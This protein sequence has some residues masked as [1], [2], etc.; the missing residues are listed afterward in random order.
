MIY[1][2]IQALEIKTLIVFNLVFDSNTI[3]SCFFLFLLIIDLYFLIPAVNSQT[4]NPTSE[5][6]IPPGTP[7]NEANGEIETELLTAET[8]KK[9]KKKKNQ[10]RLK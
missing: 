3:L 4:L 8:K 2:S 5:L 10:K 7:I 1:E 9:K 6:A